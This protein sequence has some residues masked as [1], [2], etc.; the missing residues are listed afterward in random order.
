MK[1]ANYPLR[2]VD[3]KIQ[4]AQDPDQEIDVLL[5]TPARSRLIDRNYGMNLKQLQQ[6]TLNYNS[7]VPLALLEIRDKLRRYIKNVTLVTARVFKQKSKPRTLFLEI[8][9]RTRNTEKNK[10]VEINNL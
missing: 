10:L 4:L 2:I 5:D 8:A 6:T 3:G 9:L 7:R 1:I